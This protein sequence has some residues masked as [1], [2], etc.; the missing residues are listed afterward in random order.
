[1]TPSKHFFCLLASIFLTVSA[2]LAEEPPNFIFIVSDDLSAKALGSYGNEICQTPYLD[3]LAA[4]GVQ[5]D[6]AYCQYPVCGASRASFMSGLYPETTNFLGNIKTLGSYRV[7]NEEFADHPSIGGFLRRNGYV[8]TRVSKIYHMGVPGGIEAG[9]P[10]GDEPDSWDRAYDVW[11]PETGSPGLFE[12]LSPANKHWGGAFVKIEVPDELSATQADE[13]AVTQAVAIL[14]NRALHRNQTNFLKPGEPLFLAVGLVRPHVPLVAPERHFNL[15]DIEDIHLPE[16]P[17]GDLDDVPLPNRSKANAT[18]YKMTEDQA[19]EALRSY[20]ASV[21]YMDEQ[22][23]RL[24][25]AIDRLGM[26][27]NTV[28]VFISDHGWLLGEHGSWQK[29]NLFD[30]ACQVPLIIRAPGFEESAGSASKAM[31]E[32]I[33]LYPT[34]ADLAGLSDKAPEILQGHSLV[35]LLQDPDRDDWVREAGY[36]IVG[37]LKK[38]VHR[39]I[40]TEQFRY[41]AYATDEEELYDHESDPEEHTNQVTNPEYEASLEMMRALMKTIVP[42]SE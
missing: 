27:D 17:E 36:T 33:D 19:R 3:R 11:A 35:P 10:G 22:V 26:K 39:S 16:V 28:V 1:M 18:S 15:Y 25:E 40:R 42:P 34:F 31:V 12:N 32:L 24:L 29:S 9:E 37:Q 21:T 30:P 5:F 41:S 7:V 23:G 14:E 4:E 2:A 13:M 20:Y 6:R 38:G 8:S